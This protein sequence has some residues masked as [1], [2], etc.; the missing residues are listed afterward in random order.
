M[1][2]RNVPF[3]RSLDGAQACRALPPELPRWGFSAYLVL[4]AQGQED[5]GDALETGVQM[6]T[7]QPASP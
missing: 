5:R 4:Q 2:G 7:E 3:L 6:G 1:G